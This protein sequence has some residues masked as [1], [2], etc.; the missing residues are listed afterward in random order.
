MWS[1]RDVT[2][3]I[4]LAVVT[5]IYSVLVFQIGFLLTGIPGANYFFV[6]GQAIVSS[7]TLL[8]FEGRRWRLVVVVTLFGFLSLPTYSMGAPFNVLP[9]IPLFFGAL[10]ADIIF[11]TFYSRFKKTNQLALLA[12]IYSVENFIIDGIFRMAMYPFFYSA[13][14]VSLFVNAFFLM[15]PV[16]IIESLLGGFIGYT[17][18]Q[19]IQTT[20]ILNR[21]KN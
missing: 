20:D 19:R 2:L 21:T 4:I 3:V 17:I 5:L 14:Y 8:L 11:N 15:L 12:I 10:Q 1:S 9:R 6:I 7:L 18:Y 13:D 16:I